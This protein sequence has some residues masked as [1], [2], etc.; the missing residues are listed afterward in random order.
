MKPQI[1]FTKRMQAL[2]GAPDAT[3]AAEVIAEYVNALDG[4]AEGELNRA[5]DKIAR[6]RRIRSWPTV[7][8]CIDAA[9][10]ARRNP[11]DVGLKVI[12]NF[13]RWWGERL[14]KIDTAATEADIHDQLE[15][16]RP[17]YEAKWIPQRH[18]NEATSHAEQRRKTW[19]SEHAAKIALRT[20][21]E[22]E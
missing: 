15:I 3:I 13:D 6:T 4:Y 12:G 11:A 7:A 8:E 21:G 16:I 1:H 22:G 19:K 2:F 14:A 5:A 18:W 10:E 20:I 9:E 17:Y